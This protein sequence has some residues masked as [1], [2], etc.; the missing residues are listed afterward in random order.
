MSKNSSA[1]LKSQAD[2][3]FTLM[4]LIPVYY[5]K[6]LSHATLIALEIVLYRSQLGQ[7]SL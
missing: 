6:V 5:T 7:Y 2:S 1:V 4:W 3:S